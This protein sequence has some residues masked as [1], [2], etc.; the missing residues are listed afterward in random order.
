[1]AGPLPDALP[2]SRW[3]HRWAVLTT[4][5]ALPLLALGA[6]VTTRHAGMAD[7]VWPT[8]PWHLLLV[9]WTEPRAGFLIEH[10]HRLV[11][12][13]VGCGGIALAVTLW[14]CEPRRWLCWLGTAVLAGIVVQ[15]LLGGFRV[16]LDQWF[17]SDLAMVHGSFAPVVFSLLTSV[18]VVT[19]QGWTTRWGGHTS[20]ARPMWGPAMLAA[21][22]IYVQ[23]VFGSLVRHTYSSV[24]PRAHVLV[25]FCVAIVVAWLTRE[26]WDRDRSE[27]R[28]RAS[29]AVLA[30]LT[31]AQI[32][33]GT[34]A[35]ML[36]YTGAGLTTQSV[37]PTAHVLVGYLMLAASVVVSLK[38]FRLAHVPALAAAH[39]AGPLGGAA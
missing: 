13:L 26:A 4:V 32:L 27:K 24:G 3:P 35:W 15:G 28:L 10:T 39:V 5:G 9:S 36:R 6:T 19:S 30:A 37:V 1:M 18:A 2:S 8:Y 17:G 7:P 22:L 34:E 38:A 31:A 23:I 11:G 33:L 25:A 12:Y 16:K 20:E 21:G 29:V 14:W